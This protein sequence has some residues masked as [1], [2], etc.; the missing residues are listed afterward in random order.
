MQ[1]KINPVLYFVLPDGTAYKR[2]DR[3]TSAARNVQLWVF[4]LQTMFKNIRI[5][6]EDNTF[7]L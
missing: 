5:F 7:D 4:V 6:S 2:E 1:L 3:V